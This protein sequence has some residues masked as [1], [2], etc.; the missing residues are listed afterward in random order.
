MYENNG[1]NYET[2]NIK[3]DKY[4]KLIK[5]TASKLIQ[6]KEIIEHHPYLS[7]QETAERMGISQGRVSQL[8]K[9]L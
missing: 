5:K 1:S 6:L 3:K 4:S 7:Q 2:K 9:L 8:K